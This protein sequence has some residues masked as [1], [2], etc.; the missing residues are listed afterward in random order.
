MATSKRAP[1]KAA[2]PSAPTSY[3]HGDLRNALIREGRQLLEEVG[4]R[5]M[6]LRE[7]ARRVGVSEAAPSRHFEGKDALLAAIA[8]GGYEELAFERQKILESRLTPLEAMRRMM[9]AYIEFARNHAG[10]FFLMAGPRILDRNVYPDLLQSS[11]VSF[12]LFADSVCEFAEM[13]GWPS[14]KRNHVVIAAWSV[15]HGIANLILS[16]RLPRSSHSVPIDEMIDFSLAVLCAGISAG[17][18]EVKKMRGSRKQEQTA[19]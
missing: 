2:K 8:Q 18:A 10:V 4:P 15:E 13:H 1:R 12:S 5:D 9:G 6:S 11:D 17:P 3:H 14:S 19:R 16:N 7:V